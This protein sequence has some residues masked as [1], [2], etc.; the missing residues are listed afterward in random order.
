MSII[1]SIIIIMSISTIYSSPYHN[2]LWLSL[3][4]IVHLEMIVF[5]ES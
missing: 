5:L 1:M 4:C 3:F 2:L